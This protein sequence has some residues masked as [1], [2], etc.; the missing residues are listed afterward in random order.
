VPD[1]S[2]SRQLWQYEK[3]PIALVIKFN[4]LLGKKTPYSGD[5]VENVAII[6]KRNNSVQERK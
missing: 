4:S 3:A 2:L 5:W 6:D 1:I